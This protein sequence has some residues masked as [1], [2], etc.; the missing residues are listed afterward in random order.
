MGYWFFYGQDKIGPWIESALPYTQSAAHLAFSFA[1]PTLALALAGF[2]RW[3]HRAYFALLALVGTAVAVGAYPYDDPSPLGSALK[4]FAATSTAGLALRSTGRAT[5]LVVLSLATFLAVGIS[6]LATRLEARQR[7]GL[8]VAAAALAGLLVLLNL[9]AL[10]QG[11]F[12]GANLQRDEAIPR[13]WTQAI[14]AV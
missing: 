2:T 10:W 1:L 5:P 11:T 3:R 8:A 9:P 13:Y 4:G 7:S 6:A 14:R 12:Y